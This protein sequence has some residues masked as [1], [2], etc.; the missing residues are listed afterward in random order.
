MYQR[1]LNILLAAFLVA[2]GASYA[3]YRLVGK[4]IGDNARNHSTKIVVAAQDLEIGAVIK[5]ADLKTTDLVAH[6]LADAILKPGSAVGQGV[7]YNNVHG[8]ACD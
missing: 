4:Q 2:A 1:L 6:H 3:V 8:R 7:P 5:A